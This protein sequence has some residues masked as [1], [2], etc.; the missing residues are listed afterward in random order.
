MK[1]NNLKK[2]AAASMLLLTLGGPAVTFAT[3]QSTGDLASISSQVEEQL[4]IKNGDFNDG[5]NNWIVSNP[6]TQ[7]PKIE[8]LN[9]NKYVVATYGENIHQ[10]LT[11]KPNTTYTFGYD[12]AGSADF[13]AKVEFGTM[14]HDEGFVSLEETAHNNENWTRREFTFTTPA[15]ENTY[16][17]RFSSTG[18]GWAKFDNIQ[19]EPE[20][21]ETNLLTLGTQDREAYAYLN[22]DSERFNSSERLMVYV[23]GRYHFETYKGKAYYSFTSKKDGGTQVRRSISGVKGQVIEVYTAPNSPGHSSTGKRLL[24]SITLEEDLAVDTSLLDH[25]VKNIKLSG[26]RLDIDF[27]RAS[28]EGKNRMMI[29]KNGKYIAEVYKGKAYYSSVREKLTDSIKVS[30]SS[31]FKSGDVISVELRS[32]TPGGSAKLIQVLA[33][34]EVE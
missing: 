22:L 15:T 29:Y 5:L 19:V 21:T 1:K 27:D 7:N 28:F 14:N 33:T 30:K 13:P 10:Y 11:L 31:D 9:G 4:A 26:S 3:S 25:A 24:E 18:N 2:I 34:F 12:V 32:G 6:G 17:L 23:D 16:I 20:K 8:E